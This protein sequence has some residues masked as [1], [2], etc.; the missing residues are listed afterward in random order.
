MTAEHEQNNHPDDETMV[1]D[2]KTLT[3]EEKALKGGLHVAH[4]EDSRA[5][6][7]ESESF[8]DLHQKFRLE[9]KPSREAR[10]EENT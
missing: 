8:E 1:V 5:N 6:L 7:L 4:G 10:T 3:P 9:P 2:K